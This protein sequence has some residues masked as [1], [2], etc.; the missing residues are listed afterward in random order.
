VRQLRGVQE[1]TTR[2]G[3]E[4]EMNH[5]THQSFTTQQKISN[6]LS[7]DDPL[8]LEGLP[9]RFLDFCRHSIEGA[10]GDL[11]YAEP[12]LQIS[13]GRADDDVSNWEVLVLASFQ[14]EDII[15]L[16]PI[17]S[18]RLVVAVDTSTIRLGEYVNGSLC[19]LRGAVVLLERNRYRYVRYGPLIFSLGINSFSALQDLAIPGWRAFSSEPNIDGLLKRVR[20]A[21]ERWLQFNVSTSLSHG[22]I[23][24]DGSLT[25][26]TPDNPSKEVER[27]LEEARRSGSMVIAISKKTKLRINNQSITDLLEN[28]S[29]P[30]LLNVDEEVTGQFPPYP[31]RF[32]GRVFVGKLARAG[33]AFRMDVDRE[34]PVQQTADGF[35]QL[36]GTDVVD[37]GYPETLRFAHILSTFTANDVLAMQAFSC[38]RL[39]VQLI[40]KI[41]LRRSLFG[42]FGTAWEAYH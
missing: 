20:N 8:D 9:D 27:I 6:F 21:L 23:L 42:P 35:D 3:G 37:Q 15:P 41:A 13:T 38:A 4:S 14:D 7:A 10:K 31:V 26:G 24:I 30:C 1:R 19:A 36:V 22:I 25:A 32:L 11:I 33:Y 28:K 2:R 5:R 39:G 29:E 16:Q 34:I 17:P 18:S 12:A 40:P